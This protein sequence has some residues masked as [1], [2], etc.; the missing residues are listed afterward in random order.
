MSYFFV[1]VAVL[2]RE[3]H[4]RVDGIVEHLVDHGTKQ[5]FV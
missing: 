5:F 1:T 2:K 4:C 3:L